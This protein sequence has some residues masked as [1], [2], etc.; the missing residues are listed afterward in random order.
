MVF[1]FSAMSAAVMRTVPVALLT[2][3]SRLYILSRRIGGSLG[4]AFVASQIM[5]RTVLHHARLAEHLTSYSPTS[6]QVFDGLAG[7][8]AGRGLP[9]GIA[10]ESALKLLGGGASPGNSDGS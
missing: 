1:T 9:Q 10:E 5:H 6:M 7:Q 2:A 8:L 3:A 4:Y